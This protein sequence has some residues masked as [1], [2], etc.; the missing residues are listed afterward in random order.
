[1]LKKKF[2]SG[3]TMVIAIVIGMWIPLRGSPPSQLAPAREPTGRSANI[4]VTKEGVRYLVPPDKIV[5]G[6]PAKDGIP[7]IDHPKFI[8]VEEADKWLADDESVLAISCNG[9]DRVY[10]L[11]ILVWHEIVNDMIGGN[12]IV[13]TYCPLCGSG[14]AYERTIAGEAVE[15]GT[16]GKLYNSNLVMYDRKTDTYWSQI[17][18]LAILGELAGER[19]VPVSI[20]TV[21]WGDWKVAHPESEVLSRNTGYSRSYGRDPYG[22]YYEDDSIWF[23]VEARDD[24]VHPKTVMFGIE[25]NGV[26]KAY[27]ESDLIAQGTIDDTIGAVA[28]SIK[29]DPAGIVSVTNIESGEEIVKEREFWFAW[30]AFHPETLLYVDERG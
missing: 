26:Y 13:I 19:L 30:Y 29:R 18:G 27:R 7:S 25:V 28:I 12:P 22:T 17:G 5:S 16:S 2:I 15:F 9:V 6:G 3:L 11:Q 14:I 4:Q 23:P 24:R 1:M 21:V 20:D 8:S 10:P